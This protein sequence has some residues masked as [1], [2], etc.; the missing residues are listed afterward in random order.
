[1]DTLK[2]TVPIKHSGKEGLIKEDNG[3]IIYDDSWLHPEINDPKWETDFLRKVSSMRGKGRKVDQLDKSASLYID[4]SKGR[5]H[6]EKLVRRPVQVRGKNGKIFTRMQW[7]DPET[8]QPVGHHPVGN[9]SPTQKEHIDNFVNRMSKQEKYLALERHNVQWQRHENPQKDHMNAVMALKEHYHKNPHLAGAEHLPKDEKPKAPNGK[10]EAHAWVDQISKHPEHLYGLMK[11][12]GIA[13]NDPRLNKDDKAAPIK[14]MHNMMKLKAH[15]TENPHLM[16]EHGNNPPMVTP[17]KPKPEEPTKAQQGGNTIDGVLKRM[18]SADLYNLMKLKGIAEEDPRLNTN[19]KAA[20]IK[21]MHNMMKLKK[22]IEQDPSILNLDPNGED[23]DQEA[24]RRREQQHAGDPKKTIADWLNGLSKDHKM[25]LLEQYKDSPY[26]K[27]RKRY[28]NPNIDYMRGVEAL[29]EHF[30][31]NP[32][33]MKAHGKE[34]DNERLM[35]M[36]IGNKNMAK[37]LRSLGG[38]KNV[39]DVKIVEDGVEWKFA[40]GFVRREQDDDGNPILSIVHFGK[41]GDEWNESSIDLKNAEKLLNGEESAQEAKEEVKEV[42]L[43][44]RPVRDI[45]EALHQDFDKNYSPALDPKLKDEVSKAWNSGNMSEYVEELAKY[46]PNGGDP[47]VYSKLLKK[48]G[49]QVEDSGFNKG[50][51]YGKDGPGSHKF[52][53]IVYGHMVEGTKSKNARDYVIHYPSGQKDNWVLHQSAK[54]WTKGEL[55]DARRD[56]VKH[57]VH[58]SS[59]LETKHGFSDHTSRVSLLTSHVHE[60]LQHVPFDLLTDM[61][62]H[63]DTKIMFHTKS[64]RGEELPTSHYSPST[65]NILMNPSYYSDDG[66][67][68]KSASLHQPSNQFPLS[69]AVAHEFAHAMDHFFAGNTSN[70]GAG[71]WKSRHAEKYMGEYANALGEAYDDAV[72]RS[73]PGMIVGSA[74]GYLYHKDEWMSTYQGKIYDP[75]YYNANAS[76]VLGKDDQGRTI[77]NN[78]GNNTNKALEFWSEN[79]SAYINAKAAHDRYINENEAD[80]EDIT[81]MDVWASNQFTGATKMGFGPQ[82]GTGSEHKLFSYHS[83]YNGR[84]PDRGFGFLYHHLRTTHPKLHEALDHLFGRGDFAGKEDYL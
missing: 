10:D 34:A 50:M 62:T 49:V 48:W 76:Y 39:G 72:K 9:D 42:P 64:E 25:R 12:F 44:E 38:F 16:Q 32:D 31:A 45:L 71:T 17:P 69:D 75:R 11:K 40:D 35:G 41:N 66:I 65:G 5:L 37:I 30:V 18:P 79:M 24:K 78:K 26:L 73:N 29:K 57:A 14:H 61:F 55:N 20:P 43:H 68:R 56:F 13:D 53:Q 3:H 60:S 1:M 4:L 83:I 33:D 80:D 81:P 36:K 52:K 70:M 21:H 6:T 47:E 27:D 67:F 7:V 19:D 15:I 54:K 77:D 51:F 82:E 84:N 8:G 58:V 22:L 2:R 59:D 46:A 23:E 28:D 63:R 74:N